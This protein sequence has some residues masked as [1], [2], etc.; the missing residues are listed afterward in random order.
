MSTE[1]PSGDPPAE[2]VRT[3]E[4]TVAMNEALILGAVRQ[5]EVS[6]A[7]ESLNAQLQAEITARLETSGE[8]AEKARLLELS[9]DA[10]IVRGLDDRIT[11]W[12]R[13][14]QKLYGWSSEE[15]IGK[16]LDILSKWLGTRTT[17]P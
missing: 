2:F 16:D 5:H 14:A 12:N 6:E 4:M 15:V 3:H 17:S 8:L 13:G 9:N 11:S 1:R 10:I 7:A